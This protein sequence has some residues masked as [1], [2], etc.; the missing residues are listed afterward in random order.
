MRAGRSLAVALPAVVL[1]CLLAPLFWIESTALALGAGLLL[2]A[3]AVGLMELGFRAVFRLVLKR[4]YKL[5]RKVPFERI[6]AE[7]HPYLPYAYKKSFLMQ[8][9]APLDSQ[10]HWGEGYVHPRLSTN[11]YRHVNGPDGGR[12]IEVPKPEGLVRVNCLGAST[13]ENY[14][15][16][17]GVHYSYPLALE[18]ILRE[19]FPDR[20]IEV[21]NCGTQGWTSAEILVKFLLHTADTDPDFVVWYHANND[22]AAS[23]TPDFESDYSHSRK[24]FAEAYARFR[25]A[26]KFPDVPL[27]VYN[28]IMHSVLFQNP[29]HG[30]IESIQKAPADIHGPFRGLDTYRRNIEHLIA[31]CRFRGMQLVLST[32]CQFLF[33]RIRDVPAYRKYAEGIAGENRVVRELAERHGL[34]LVDN[35]ER[36]PRETKYFID[37]IH[38]TPEGMEELARN[39]AEPI[40]AALEGRR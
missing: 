7:P 36:V 4:P 24:S 30:L 14:L 6:H 22:L 25:L 16:K 40:A 29:R 28:V 31:V 15:G 33:D 32:Y 35:A 2:A 18:R 38:F 12:D 13:T 10:L 1:L 11:N 20:R 23:L 37:S 5:K 39:L 3:L 8:R 19:R 26:S 21:N 34:P 27:A 9:E 17:E